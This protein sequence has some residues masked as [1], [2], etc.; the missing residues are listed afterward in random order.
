MYTLQESAQPAGPA[1]ERAY[2]GARESVRGR[3]R[4]VCVRVRQ[5]QEIFNH[6]RFSFRLPSR[7]GRDRETSEFAAS[8][9]NTVRKSI[10]QQVTSTC[11]LATGWTRFK[12]LILPPPSARLFHP[13]VH[14]RGNPLD[15]RAASLFPRCVRLDEIC[16]CKNP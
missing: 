13:P 6:D 11:R 16:G 2:V 4:R 10:Q 7:K 8:S 14:P 15:V 12:V 9:S 1:G 5:T 3:M